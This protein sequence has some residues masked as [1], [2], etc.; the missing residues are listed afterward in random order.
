VV[1]STS[2][3]VA[4][5]ANRLREET[6]PVTRLRMLAL[7]LIAAILGVAS[8]SDAREEPPPEPAGVPP[9]HAVV[10]ELFTSQGCITCPPADRLLV[11]LGEESAGRVV[12]LSFH[13]DFWNSLGWKDPFSR[14]AW[15]ERQRAYARALRLGQV[16]T[17]QAVVDGRS[18]MNGSDSARLRAAIAAAASRPAGKISLLLEPSPSQILVRARVDLPEALRGRKLDLMLA[19]FERGLVTAVGRGENGGRTLHNDYVVRSLRRVGRVSS[20]GPAETSH[21]AML[22]LEKEWERSRLGVAG[23][24]QDPGS[25]EIYGAN[26][27]LLSGR[28][29]SGGGSSTTE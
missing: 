15:T 26:A 25:L 14:G 9:S 29:G 5:A 1:I 13:V 7:C 12:P 3:Q 18:E 28:Q 8:A 6:P 21:D 17:P 24:L 19:L 11:S 10:V 20:R 16:Y 22:S 27:M 2:V 4:I 23:F